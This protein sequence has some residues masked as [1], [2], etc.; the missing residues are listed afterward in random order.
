MLHIFLFNLVLSVFSLSSSFDKK[1]SQKQ[2]GIGSLSNF[3]NNPVHI[4][5]KLNLET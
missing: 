3:Q 5:I 4:N 2:C 1:K